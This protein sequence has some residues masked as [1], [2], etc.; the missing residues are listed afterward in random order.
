MLRD[1]FKVACLAL[2]SQLMVTDP[3]A[4]AQMGGQAAVTG[5]PDRPL[6]YARGRS[7]A[8]LDAYLAYLRDYSGPVGLPWYREVRP[9]VY[10]LETGNLRPNPPARLF[11]REQ[12]ERRFGFR[13]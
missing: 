11:T 7:F 10:Q 4:A 1:G 3:A 12:L 6:P 2:A 9:G 8:S 13:R 5:G